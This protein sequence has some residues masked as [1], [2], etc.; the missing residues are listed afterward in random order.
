MKHWSTLGL[1]ALLCACSGGIEGLMKD[2]EQFALGGDP[3]TPD[4]QP[5]P[6]EKPADPAAMPDPTAM[7]NAMNM[8]S[9]KTE[10]KTSSSAHCCVN[11]AYY[12]C[13]SGVKAAQCL[14]EPMKLM[15]CVQGCGF[16]SSCEPKC[17]K[18]HGPDPS[19]CTRVMAKDGECRTR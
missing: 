7:M 12:T 15:Q 18:A 14:G 11:G 2:A 1:A 8:G 9:A 10:T 5:K 16:D 4:A 17:I 13:D 19:P 6:A 3:K